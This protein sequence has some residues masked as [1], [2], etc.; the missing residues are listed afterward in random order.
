MELGEK[1]PRDREVWDQSSGSLATWTG[2]VDSNWLS[3]T[4]GQCEKEQ[5]Q[6]SLR[7][8]G[9][10]YSC[11]QSHGGSEPQLWRCTGQFHTNS[12]FLIRICKNVQMNNTFFHTM[13][14]IRSTNS[15]VTEFQWNPCE[16]PYSPESDPNLIKQ[17]ICLKLFLAISHGP[18]CHVADEAQ[19]S[20]PVLTF[21]RHGTQVCLRSS[22][23]EQVMP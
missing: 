7:N 15:G 13:Y 11:P 1:E 4:T 18:S 6:V 10:G 19:V 5:R 16:I 17:I 8:T 21:P 12:W 2:L 22:F 20:I 3:H 14:K 9:T 23:S